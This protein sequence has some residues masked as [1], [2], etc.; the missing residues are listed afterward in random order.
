[1]DENGRELLPEQEISSPSAQTEFGDPSPQTELPSAPRLTEEYYVE[2]RESVEEGEEKKKGTTRRLIRYVAAT[3]AAVGLLA[4]A[5]PAP[6]PAP[7]PT[8]A[9]IEYV[10]MKSTIVI[11]CS[12]ILSDEP[13]ILY[14]SDFNSEPRVGFTDWSRRYCIVEPDGTER[15]I[16]SYNVRNDAE[17]S[18]FCFEREET[19]SEQTEN[20]VYKLFSFNED[21]SAYRSNSEWANFGDIG[22]HLAIAQVGEVPEGSS[23]KI[24][25]TYRMGGVWC[26]ENTERMIYRPGPEP[27]IS[28]S[29]ETEPLGDGFSQAHFHT[30][31]HPQEGDDF[32]YYFGE[33]G[34]LMDEH[35]D[36][37]APYAP[38]QAADGWDGSILLEPIPSF[39][40]R[41]YD[42][43]HE[44]L[45]EGW[46]Y[47]A[48]TSAVWYPYPSVRHEG[49]DFII[50]YDGPVQS[51]SPN[52]DA[53]F[54]SLELHLI[55]GRTGWHYLIETEQVPITD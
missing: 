13:E 43:G 29:L 15:E 7:T 54:Y 23:L 36:Y 38:L 21:V 22:I 31:I 27:E 33:L 37:Y 30:V 48:P 18:R 53:A 47:V 52:E 44:F 50:E 55:D 51:S 14:F 45:H 39:C 46:H 11:E 9:P 17:H 20:T 4:E 34:Q 42:A 26:R 8:P 3:A 12:V 19:I 35:E 28:V 16:P 1:M 24:T 25:D 6:A 40:V 49:R 41:W 32:V 5:A 10:E 2:R